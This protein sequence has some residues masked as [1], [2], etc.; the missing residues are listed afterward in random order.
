MSV[1]LCLVAEFE[2]LEDKGVD[3][4]LRVNLYWLNWTKQ[5]PSVTLETRYFPR[6]YVMMTIQFPSRLKAGGVAC[7]R[8]QATMHSLLILKGADQTDF[9]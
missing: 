3:D 8:I 4:A 7:R 6:L 9:S 5:H 1:C 2:Q